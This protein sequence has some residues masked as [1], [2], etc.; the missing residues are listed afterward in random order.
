MN[1]IPDLLQSMFTGV[2]GK[3]FAAAQNGIYSD[4][5]FIKPINGNKHS[6][7]F[8]SQKNLDHECASYITQLFMYQHKIDKCLTVIL[9]IE[10]E[11]KFEVDWLLREIPWR[12]DLQM[13]NLISE[14][15]IQ[16]KWNPKKQ[17]TDRTGY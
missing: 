7:L 3:L 1:F 2:F 13:E 6:I 16:D 8:I 17:V 9:H 12:R 10:D 5:M 11:D 14:L 15:N 4:D